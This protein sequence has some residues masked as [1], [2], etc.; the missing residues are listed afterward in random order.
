[1][2]PPI[3]FLN[4]SRSSLSAF[5]N[6]YTIYEFVDRKRF[7]VY[8]TSVDNNEFDGLNSSSNEQDKSEKHVTSTK[9]TLHFL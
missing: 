2:H 1:M 6:K 3:H 7:R 9:M 4:T 5:N 8:L